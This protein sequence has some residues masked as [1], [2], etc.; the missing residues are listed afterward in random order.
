MLMKTQI[1]R[2][3]DHPEQKS[4]IRAI[5]KKTSSPGSIFR[6]IYHYLNKG[7][8]IFSATSRGADFRIIEC[9]EAVESMERMNRKFLIGKFLKDAM[10]ASFESG[11]FEVI[12][13]VYKTKKSCK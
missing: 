8:I 1:K 13:R 11:L 5:S 12:H 3:K 4:Q 6:E 2:K 10:P 9:N 7:I